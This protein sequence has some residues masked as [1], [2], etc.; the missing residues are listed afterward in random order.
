MQGRGWPGGASNRSCVGIRFLWFPV[1]LFW[2]MGEVVNA[3]EKH[4]KWEEPGEGDFKEEKRE[5]ESSEGMNLCAF[6]SFCGAYVTFT[7]VHWC[8]TV[9]I[10]LP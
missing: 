6:A 5:K 3:G 4:V 7:P 8:T 10:T 1:L 2:V 9:C